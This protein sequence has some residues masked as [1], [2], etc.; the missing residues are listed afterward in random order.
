MVNEMNKTISAGVGSSAKDTIFMNCIRGTLKVLKKIKLK[1]G[2]K[3]KDH[4]KIKNVFLFLIN[5]YLSKNNFSAYR[6]AF[7]LSWYNLGKFQYKYC[8]FVYIYTGPP[9]SLNMTPHS[10]VKEGTILML[11][12]EGTEVIPLIMLH[13]QS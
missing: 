4:L 13:K 6:C 9:P 7:G 2:K 12:L 10:E 8:E 5:V 3:E 1:C 11:F